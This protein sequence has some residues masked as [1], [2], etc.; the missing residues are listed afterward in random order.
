MWKD[1][2]N[3]QQFEKAEEGEGESESKSGQLVGCLKW[4]KRM[5][6]EFMVRGSHEP[7]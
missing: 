3:C 2:Q 7:M 1:D 6:D 4:V 5:M